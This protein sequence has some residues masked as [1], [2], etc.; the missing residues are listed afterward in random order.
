VVAAAR[1]AAAVHACSPGGTPLVTRDLRGERS[2]TDADLALLDP[3]WPEMA[4]QL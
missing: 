1:M 3:V 4:G 2:A